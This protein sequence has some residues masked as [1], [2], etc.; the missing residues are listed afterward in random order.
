MKK[1]L[2]ILL[3][4]IFASCDSLSITAYPQ[5][6]NTYYYPTPYYY[7]YPVSYPTYQPRY[8]PNKYYRN[9]HTHRRR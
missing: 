9:N 8:S 5:P 6:Y 7:L 1:I 3:L 4:F 2:V